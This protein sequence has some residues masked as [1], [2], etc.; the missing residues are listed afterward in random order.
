MT[1]NEILQALAG[2]TIPG[3]C[4]HCQAHQT[5]TDAGCSVHV[6]T[7]HH[8]DTCP[9]YKRQKQRRRRRRPHAR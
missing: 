1:P 7:V 9:V 8:D 3:G 4:D 5:I 2:H 6:L